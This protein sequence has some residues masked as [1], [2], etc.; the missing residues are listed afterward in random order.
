MNVSN[1]AVRARQ[2]TSTKQASLSWTDTVATSVT[3]SPLPFPSD[4]N[5]AV[6]E[7]TDLGRSYI[8][9]LDFPAG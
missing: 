9:G 8:Q 1:T 7:K 3:L 6:V 2:E 5:K 4:L